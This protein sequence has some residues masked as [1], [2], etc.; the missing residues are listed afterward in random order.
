MKRNW[1]PEEL[2]EHWTLLPNELD[3][4]ANKTGPTRLGFAILGFQHQLIPLANSCS[5]PRPAAGVFQGQKR[6]LRAGA[7]TVRDRFRCRGTV[8]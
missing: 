3:L 4:L 5:G 7:G 6:H 1:S 2:V 8:N